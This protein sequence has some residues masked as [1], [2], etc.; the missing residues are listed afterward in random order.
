MARG[1]HHACRS[2]ERFALVFPVARPAA[3]TWRGLYT[4]LAGRQDTAR[5]RWAGAAALARRRGMPY[6]EA[7]VLYQHGR[8]APDPEGRQMLKA[9]AAIFERLGCAYDLAETRQILAARK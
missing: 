1:A 2:L 5:H 4:W 3:L 7:R 6:D 9:A 8:H